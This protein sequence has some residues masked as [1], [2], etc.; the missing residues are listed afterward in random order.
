VGPS[1]PDGH[2]RKPD[3]RETGN[4]EVGACRRAPRVGHESCQPHVTSYGYDDDGNLASVTDANGHTTAYEYDGRGRKTKRTLPLGQLETFAYDEQNQVSHT[5]FRGKTTTMTYDE[6]GRLRTRVPDP[7]FGETTESYFYNPTGTRNHTA[8]G[9]GTTSYTYDLRD[10]I[11]TK[12]TGAGTLTYTYDATGNLATIRSSNASGTSVDYAWD[13]GNQLASVTDNRAGGMTVAAYTQ[14]GRPGTL[15]QPNGVVA[16]YTYDN[17]DRVTSL[18]WRRGTSPTFA[19]WAYNHNMRGQRT[20]ATDAS[21]RSAAYGY[22]DTSRLTSETITGAGAGH[23]GALTYTLDPVGNRLSRTSTL[24]ALGNQTFSYDPND[25]LTTDGYD[26]NGNTTSSDGDTYVYDSQNRL[27]SKTGPGGTVTLVYDCD[28]NRVAKTAGGV[29]TQYLVDDLN[30]TG[31]L[32]VL[33]EVQGG[34]VQVRYTY[35]D[36]L[37]SQTRGVGAAPAT[38][39]YGYDAHGNVTFLTDGSGS[40]TDTY[41]YD[42][43]GNLVASAGLTPT[44]RLFV[45]E[46]FDPDLGLINL[47]ARLYRSALGRFLNIDPLDAVATAAPRVRDASTGVFD[48]DLR[49]I[50]PLVIPNQILN[51]RLFVPSGQHRYQYG[52]GDPVLNIDPSGR[53]AIAEYVITILNDYT[54]IAGRAVGLY[55]ARR[56]N[57]LAVL[58]GELSK[59]HPSDA[60]CIG[61]AL[62]ATSICE[63]GL[64]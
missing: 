31:Y 14:T 37:V 18:A 49:A 32:Q 50:L 46:E 21:G 33:E 35:G 61:R 12:A 11:L 59:C 48:P 38:S 1:G 17:L 28:G 3:G 10:R 26:P 47:R 2:V 56:F 25:Q 53:D 44:T 5:D 40:V 16:T 19:S 62:A 64:N 29:T 22:D 58:L 7:S 43:W 41:T 54:P 15:T 42:A 20:S 23:D 60:T 55:I 52:S 63:L 51:E 27:V 8:D 39:Y 34:G 6:V 13:A 36:K 30:P 24:A 9:S 45:G 4:R 57:C